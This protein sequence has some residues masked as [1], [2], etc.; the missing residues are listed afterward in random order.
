MGSVG[1]AKPRCAKAQFSGPKRPST[2]RR[3]MAPTNGGRISGRSNSPPSSPCP[4]KRVRTCQYA[5]GYEIIT[6]SS[7]TVAAS[8]RLFRS[9]RHAGAS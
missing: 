8:A 9:Q 4:R 2:R 1:S 3:P 6:H 7:V 5:S